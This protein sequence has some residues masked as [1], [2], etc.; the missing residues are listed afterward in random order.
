M[1]DKR[2]AFLEVFENH[3]QAMRTVPGCLHLELWQELHDR[4]AVTTYSIWQSEKDLENYR[5]SKL[6]QEVWATV[7]PWF[8]ASAQVQS[9]TKLF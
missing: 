6:F 8:A 2:E 4:A 1:S 7:K 9:L 3:R 5:N